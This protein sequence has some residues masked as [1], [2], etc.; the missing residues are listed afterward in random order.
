MVAQTRPATLEDLAATPDDGRIYE[1]LNGEI[2]VSAAP[3]WKHQV[4]LQMLNRSIDGWVVQHGTGI[5]LTAP[6]DIVLDA[7]N[8]LQPD[9]LYVG[10]DN[11]GRVRNGRFHGA[12]DLAV[13]I[14]SPTSRN[15]D[16]TVKAMRYALAGIREFWLVDPDLRTIALFELDGTFYTERAPESDGVFV[17]GVLTGLRLD[18]A[19]VFAAA[20]RVIQNG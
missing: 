13:E 14:I 7:E 2:V 10:P 12:P 9:L 17:S 5:A 20:D 11:P 19:S 18:P 6:V 8:V 4:V 15:R 1:L 3:T 16:A